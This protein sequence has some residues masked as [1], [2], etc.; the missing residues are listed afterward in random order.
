M[1]RYRVSAVHLFCENGFVRD[2]DNKQI[3]L[4]LSFSICIRC[5]PLDV[6]RV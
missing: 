3:G 6:A 4:F 2:Y 5:G 1:S